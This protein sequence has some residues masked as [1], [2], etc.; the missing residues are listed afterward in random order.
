[1][2]SQIHTSLLTGFV[3]DHVRAAAESRL[4]PEYRRPRLVRV[5][6]PRPIR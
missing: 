2:N 5:V 1:M 4:L 3:E 6:R